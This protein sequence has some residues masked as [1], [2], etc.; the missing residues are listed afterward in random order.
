MFASD[1]ETITTSFESSGRRRR[2]S[3]RRV[4]QHDENGTPFVKMDGIVDIVD[5]E[6][7][8]S[9]QQCGAGT[10]RIAEINSWIH[11]AG[12]DGCDSITDMAATPKLSSITSSSINVE[13]TS[14]T[15]GRGGTT[16]AR[17]RHSAFLLQAWFRL[18]ESIRTMGILDGE[19]K[20]SEVGMERQESGRGCGPSVRAVTG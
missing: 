1:A 18:S 10:Q 11:H 15:N 13:S 4:V 12:G 17:W 20:E 3:S 8:K 16:W 2:P 19:S 14:I 5:I 7:S 9:L 6:I